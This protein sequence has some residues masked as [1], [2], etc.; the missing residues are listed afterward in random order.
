MGCRND[1]YDETTSSSE[2]DDKINELEAMLCALTSELK[3][4]TEGRQIISRAEKNGDVNII[5]WIMLHETED[6]KRLQKQ[7][8]RFSF[9][10]K[11]MLKKMLNK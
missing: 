11:E 6:E 4:D 5:D 2:K 10:E 7:L 1:Y 9:H 3:K 8:E